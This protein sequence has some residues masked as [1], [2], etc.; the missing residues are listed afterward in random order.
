MARFT[1]RRQKVEENFGALFGGLSHQA[2]DLVFLG[3]LS[4][5][6]SDQF[7]RQD[8]LECSRP[9]VLP[10]P[11]ISISGF[12]RIGRGCLSQTRFQR[13]KSIFIKKLRKWPKTNSFS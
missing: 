6:F 7:V 9:E 2:D 4:P 8:L 3:R 5:N 10:D 12:N 1:I 13:I 11:M